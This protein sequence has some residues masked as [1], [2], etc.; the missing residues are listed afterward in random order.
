MVQFEILI[1]S[2]LRALVEIA[3]Y[4]LLGQG[5]LAILAGTKREQ[6]VFYRILRTITSPVIRAVRFITPRFIIDAHIPF[7][8][9]FLLFWLWVALSFAKRYLCVTH[10]LQC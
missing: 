9:F 5:L 6:N 4:S 8:S 1:I 2:I 7:L 10:G 3:G